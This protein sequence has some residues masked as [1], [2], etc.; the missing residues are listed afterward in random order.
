MEH[1]PRSPRSSPAAC[2]DY[3]VGPKGISPA[4]NWSKHL[5]I[6]KHLPFYDAV[7]YVD[8][9]IMFVNHTYRIEDF[10]DTYLPESG[11]HT[12]AFGE[13]C[14]T[15]DFC[16]N[17]FPGLNA[18][19]IMARNR[20]SAFTV[21]RDWAEAGEDG[22]CA[23]WRTNHPL[24]QECFDLIL[25][26]KYQELGIVK[27]P[28]TILWKGSDGTWLV[29]A[30]SS[31]G[32]AFPPQIITRMAM[33]SFLYL[34]EQE[35]P[36]LYSKAR[37]FTDGGMLGRGPPWLDKKNGRGLT[38]EEALEVAKQPPGPEWGA[39]E[40]KARREEEERQKKQG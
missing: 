4:I 33:R 29:H 15:K 16:W 12:V 2:R 21:F 22:R 8:S 37:N 20:P 39:E 11:T 27:I 17:G 3:S 6:L 10:L 38:H 18:G 30:F 9:D 35:H 24:E 26:R 32:L 23:P 25:Y 36:S 13:N 14:M 28:D 19:M 40:K 7:F 34:M 31:G 1:P 5:F